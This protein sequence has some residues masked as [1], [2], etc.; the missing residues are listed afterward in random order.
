MEEPRAKLEAAKAQ[1][2]RELARHAQACAPYYAKIIE[3]RCIDLGTCTPADFPLLTKSLLMANFNDI[4]TDRRVTKQ[5]V[6]DFL[7]R[8]KDPQEKLFNRLT[9]MH[10]SGTSGE[11]GYF[12]YA[13]G[14]YV[15]VRRAAMRN[16][17][18]FRAVFPRF[19]WRLRRLR[20]AFYGATG[21]HFAGATGVASMQHGIRSLFVDARAFEVNTPLPEA[22]EKQIGRAHV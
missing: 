11:V 9:V 3:E 4:V 2:F 8:S 22:V 7:S 21:G 14:D 5:V 10:T 20:I 16:R 15:R 12:L 13:P 17:K 6:A 1:K 19:G 18:A